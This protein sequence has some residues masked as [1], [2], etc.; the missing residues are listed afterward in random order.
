MNFF[1]YTHICPYL[2]CYRNISVFAKSKALGE[3]C[4]TVFHQ[5]ECTERSK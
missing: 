2:I 1:F 3:A 5:I 4:G